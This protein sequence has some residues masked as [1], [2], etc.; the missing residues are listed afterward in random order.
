MSSTTPTSNH[1]YRP[2]YLRHYCH[3][4][5]RCTHRNRQQDARALEYP[6]Y[7][8]LCQD[9]QEEDQQ[10]YEGPAEEAVL[11]REIKIGGQGGRVALSCRLGSK[12]NMILAVPYRYGLFL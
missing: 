5:K 2:A 7:P 1:P 6:D 10:R 4:G 9:N 12:I 3:P 11:W 8:D